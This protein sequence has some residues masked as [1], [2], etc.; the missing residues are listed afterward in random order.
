M[1]SYA[2]WAGYGFFVILTLFF[3][4]FLHFSITRV[5]EPVKEPVKVS[6]KES[7]PIIAAKITG[8]TLAALKLAY[9]ATISLILLQ[10]I[11]FVLSIT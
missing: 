5:E 4:Y 11:M 10:I 8:E 1:D 6:Y 9:Y 3:A 7:A 2:E